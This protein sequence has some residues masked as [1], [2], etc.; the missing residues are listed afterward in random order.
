MRKDEEI[1]SE[2]ATK[3]ADS[4]FDVSETVQIENFQ[5]WV[6]NWVNLNP[7]NGESHR[8]YTGGNYFLTS[9]LIH[10]NKWDNHQFLTFNKVKSLGGM[11]KKGEKSTP[12]FFWKFL[13]K[14]DGAGSFPL[15]RFFRVFNIAQ[16]TLDPKDF[17]IAKGND[18]VNRRQDIDKMIQETGANI[19]YTGSQPCYIPAFDRIEIPDITKFKSE[20]DF[21][22]VLF[23]ELGHWSK[24]EKRTNR[25]EDKLSYAQEE[26]VA[27]LTSAFLCKEFGIEGKFQHTQYIAGWIKGLKE[28]PREF[29]RAVSLAVKSARFLKGDKVE[30]VETETEIE[31]VA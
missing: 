29:F 3:I 25:N 18:G 7:C 30:E 11:V 28:Q 17:P 10:V 16:T 1:Y 15:F 27:E 26:L 9:L 31:Q 12:I 6:K 14:K 5:K 4:L 8:E 13:P 20:N 2:I 24:T 22:S 23:H 21:Y 19:E